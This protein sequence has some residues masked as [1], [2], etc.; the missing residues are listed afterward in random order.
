MK[1]ISFVGPVLSAWLLS[2]AVGIGSAFCLGSAF[3]LTGVEA[4]LALGLGL[5]TLV[6]TLLQAAPKGWLWTLLLWLLGGAAA[7]LLRGREIYDSLRLTLSAASKMLAQGYPVL[8]VLSW[9][10]PISGGVTSGPFLLLLGLLLAQLTAWTVV[11]RQSALPAVLFGVIPVALCHLLTDRPPAQWALLSLVGGLCLLL[12]SQSARCRSAADGSRTVLALVLPLGALLAA[13]TLL[14]PQ[15]GYTRAPWAEQAQEQL[16]SWAAQLTGEPFEEPT[17]PSQ[18]KPPVRPYQPD[19]IFLGLVGPQKQTHSPVLEITA[20]ETRTLYLRGKTYDRYTGRGW[21]AWEQEQTP[22]GGFQTGPRYQP[23]ARTHEAAIRTYGAAE[24]AYVPYY[25]LGGTLEALKPVGDRYLQSGGGREYTVSYMTLPYG[26]AFSTPEEF[27][28]AESFSSTLLEQPSPDYEAYVLRYDL[29]LPEETRQGI[30][31]ILA[32]QE[33]PWT[34]EGVA[35]FLQGVASYDLNT[36]RVPLDEDFVLWFLRESETG[37]CVHFASAATVMLRAI[38]IPA[39]YATGYVAYCRAGQTVLVTSDTAH[40][41]VEYY[42]NGNWIPLEVT[43]GGAPQEA[44]EQTEPAQGPTD[45]TEPAPERPTQA[46]PAPEQRETEPSLPTAPG[47]KA[48]GGLRLLAGVL[49]GVLLLLLR[50]QILLAARRARLQRGGRNARCLGLWGLLQRQARAARR[51]IPR[52]VLEIA[53]KARFSQHEITRE[54]L[55]RVLAFQSDCLA[56]MRRA[57]WPVR[58]YRRY[59]LVLD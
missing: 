49:G 43:P 3:R 18:T 27:R 35:E 5:G 52:E 7:A 24:A 17:R 38:G 11:R 1:R 14:I 26:G 19:S 2:A 30:L 29:A 39:R 28:L 56:E 37:Y 32:E 15:E 31:E 57:S 47:G 41:W 33:V 51:P 4:G 23:V 48:A 42:V 10:G 16:L 6:L 45:G 44:P 50:R 25:P 59:L 53:Q 22:A 13:L 8:P 55:A 21:T 9:G 58:L 36:A 54:E 34:P 40:A 46:H 12:L 20:D